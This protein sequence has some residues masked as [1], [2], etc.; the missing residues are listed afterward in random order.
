MGTRI[1][2]LQ[3]SPS[4]DTGPHMSTT[5]TAD[6]HPAHEAHTVSS[7]RAPGARPVVQLALQG[8][9]AHGAFTWGVLDRL[10]DEDTI[11]IGQVSGTSA[12][13]LN[14]AALVCGL[15]SGGRAGAKR[16]LSRLWSGIAVAGIPMTWL[17]APLRKP[18]LGVWDDAMPLLSPYQA[19]PLAFEP[20]RLV[21]SGIVDEE[22]LNAPGPHALFTSAVH[23]QTGRCE[24]FGPG[25]LSVQALLASACAPLLFQA[26]EI[27]GRSYW[28]GSYVGNPQLWPLYGSTLDADI[29]LVELTPLERAE[30]PTTA[31]NILN[32]INEIASIQGLL[33]ELRAI[34]TINRTGT[35]ADLRLHV[36]SLPEGGSVL[37]AEPSIK[38]T[39]S[40]ELFEALR[41]AGHAACDRWLASGC[42]ADGLPAPVDI[43]ARYLER[44]AA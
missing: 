14:G 6:P 25:K 39:V 23:V 43:A 11:D 16:N 42:G 9:G 12:G 20:L 7:R 3:R 44:G 27:E 40:M 2:V 28:D 38:R 29:L 34:D 33:A 5:T 8:G 10:L 13:A 17:L 22:A 36:V 32:R 37:Q 19:N 26:V 1:A 21:L 15:A 18:G 41:Q 24:V 31:K 35:R 30:T 4:H